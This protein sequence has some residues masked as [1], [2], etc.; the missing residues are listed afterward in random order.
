MANSGFKGFGSD[1]DSHIREASQKFGMDEKVLRGFI[2]MEA[3]WRGAMSPTGAIG[4]GQ[5]IYDTWNGLAKTAEG[6]A[7]GMIPISKATF[8]KASDPRFN[9]R[10]NT[11]ATALLAKKNADMLRRS[12]LPVTGENLYMMH[13]IGPGV[14]AALRGSS[15]V[16][17]ATLKAMRQNGKRAN[18]SAADFARRQRDIF[19]GHYRIANGVSAPATQQIMPQ[20][21]YSPDLSGAVP[22]EKI[23]GK[24]AQPK[25]SLDGAVPWSQI[26]GEAPK[27]DLSGAVP[28]D[29]IAGGSSQNPTIT[30][31]A[32]PWS[33]ITQS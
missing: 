11:L 14:I 31:N 32:V 20:Q 1:V 21:A 17:S 15:N 27:P 33:Q 6:R 23:T 12:G 22:W 29:S 13:N 19:N 16:S 7:I 4:T 25:P 28:W 18:E 30:Q 24:S 2:K 26:V 9:K 3:G 5:F 8:R 10:V